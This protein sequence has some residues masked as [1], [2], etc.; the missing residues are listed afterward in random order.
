MKDAGQSVSGDALLRNALA[1]YERT[2][3]TGSEQARF[4][5]EQLGK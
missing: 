3:G 5:K 1:I 2:L 4:V